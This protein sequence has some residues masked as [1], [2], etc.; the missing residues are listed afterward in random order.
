MK[1]PIIA[2][3]VMIVAAAASIGL[4]FAA[5]DKKEKDD[6][7]AAESAADLILFSFDSNA[8]N[9]VEF[10]CSDG[11]YTAELSGSEWKLTSGGDFAL[12]QSY[13]KN[14]CTYA[15]TLKASK[16]YSRDE[17]KLSSYGLDKPSVIT[18]YDG[19]NS[20]KLNVGTLSTTGDYFYVTVD[21]RDKVYI[22]DSLYGSVL[23]AS[24][25]L[26]RA[27]DF[28]P[29][30]DSEVAEISVSASGKEVYRLTKNKDTLAWSLP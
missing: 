28:I 19:Q 5:R 8:V 11:S 6:K 20:Y 16:S 12:D 3:I 18:L 13:V 22:V 26:L 15:A 21:G 27:K 29:Y 30:S 7:A 2:L 10:T 14:V 17:S 24:R 4:Y 9:K 25:V 1:K 23:R